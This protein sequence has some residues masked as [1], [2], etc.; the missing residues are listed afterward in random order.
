MAKPEKKIDLGKK[1]DIDGDG[2]LPPV[3]LIFVIMAAIVLLG[4]ASWGLGWTS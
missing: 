1:V 3:K 2:K 4:L